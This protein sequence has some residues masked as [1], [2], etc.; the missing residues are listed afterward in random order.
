MLR[1][2]N[3]TPGFTRAKDTASAFSKM[4]SEALNY[5]SGGSKYRPGIFS[6]TPDQIDYLIGQA[7]GGVGRDLV[8]GR[9][10]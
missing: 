6:P 1:K 5:L 4:T 10:R 8:H 9:F 2:L 7:T 3:P